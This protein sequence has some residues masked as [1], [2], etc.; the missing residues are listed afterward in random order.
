MY[1]YT[2]KYTSAKSRISQVISIPFY[3]TPSYSFGFRISG[4]SSKCVKDPLDHDCLTYRVPRCSK[5]YSSTWN[6]HIAK[7]S[8]IRKLPS[9][10]R[11]SK[12]S[13]VIMFIMLRSHHVNYTLMSTTSSS[14]SW[15][16]GRVT[17]RKCSIHRSHFRVRKPAFFQV[18]WLPAVSGVAGLDLGKLS[19][20]SAGL[21]RELGLHFKMLKHV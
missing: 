5:N 4:K 14:S 3:C 1:I 7:G 20:K 17:A 21:W 2:H 9:Y 15:D 6:L 16:M 8:L 12:G 10:R 18:K 11:M 13:L 19:T